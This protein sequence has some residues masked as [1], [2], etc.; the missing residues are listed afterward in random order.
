M[1]LETI[2]DNSTPDDLN[3][4]WPLAT[5]QV[6]KGD[7]HIRNLKTVLKNWKK[8]IWS[9]PNEN[10]LINSDF[11]VWQ[12]GDS[13]ASPTLGEYVCDRW[14]IAGNGA[15]GTTNSKYQTQR[16]TEY[17]ISGGGIDSYKGI[18]QRIEAENLWGL[19]QDSSSIT[20]TLS[21]WARSDAADENDAIWFRVTKPTAKDNW[22]SEA[23]V[24]ALGKVADFPGGN[25]EKRYVHTFTVPVAQIQNGM[26]VMFGTFNEGSPAAPNTKNTLFSRAKLEVGDR[27]TE[28]VTP[29]RATNL[30]QCQRY[31]EVVDAAAG[32]F[33]KSIL[34]SNYWIIEVSYKTKKRKDGAAVSVLSS[35][36]AGTGTYYIDLHHN[37]KN[38]A[39]V[40]VGAGATSIYIRLT[41]GFDT[42]LR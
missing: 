7:D 37:T 41:L 13:K 8:W 3:K 40:S 23:D 12:R 2:D 39:G 35:E 10:L 30:D 9:T 28:Y 11:S 27:A 14:I 1:P 4:D 38:G 42:E 26:C 16:T 29:D 6:K 18:G 20:F 5:D 34:A 25:T 31:Y 21:F 19:E 17:V 22:A 36:N 24:V 32:Y 33:L 15:V